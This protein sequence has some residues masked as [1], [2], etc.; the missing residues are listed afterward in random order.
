[1]QRLR[2]LLLVAV[3]AVTVAAC[4]GGDEVSPDAAVA[5]A[6]TK[7]T[8]AGSSRVAFTASMD[9]PA[10]V[11][12]ETLEFSGEGVMNYK[13]RQGRLTYDLSGLLEAA[14]QETANAE[15][16]IIFDDLVVYMKFDLLT[17]SLP[18]GKP[19]VKIDLN[20]VAK[21]QGVN[22]GQL[23]QIAQSDPSQALSW[24][25][26]VSGNVRDVGE[27]EVR[28]VETTHYRLR[29]D[30][31][32]VA[33]RAPAATRADVRA[34]IENLIEQTGR[35]TIPMDVWVDQDGL[36]RRQRFELAFKVPGGASGERQEA[37]MTTRI[38][39][40]DFGVDAEVELPQPDQV[41]DLAKLL[42]AQGGGG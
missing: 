1:M 2:I 16:E 12:Q 32:K 6:A 33:D 36:L 30:L 19:W 35:S 20:E 15:A 26:A 7:T 37:K 10:A 31:E 3:S 41:N 13:A 4:G 8:D 23:S 39:L 42:R 21:Q 28:G 9:L 11:S 17:Q 25:K 14:G 27:E 38:D 22:L 5:D 40:F 18:G 34:S 29:V 24:L